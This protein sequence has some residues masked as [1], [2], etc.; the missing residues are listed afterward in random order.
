MNHKLKAMTNKKIPRKI[1][2]QQLSVKATK[3]TRKKSGGF[4]NVLRCSKHNYLHVEK[5]ASMIHR[6][7]VMNESSDSLLIIA[8]NVK[9]T[10]R[11]EVIRKKY[12][13]HA[14]ATNISREKL[15]KCALV[16]RR[17]LMTSSIVAVSPP[18]AISLLFPSTPPYKDE[19]HT[20]FLRVSWF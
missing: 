9:H 14:A 5:A 15:E 11:S 18:S 3:S 8:A 7:S 20:L 4:G 6:L 2:S 16:S 17:F 13:D 19:T 10:H 1:G 12:C